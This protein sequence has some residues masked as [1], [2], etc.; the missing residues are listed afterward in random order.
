ME[1]VNTEKDPKKIKKVLKK[2]V[3]PNLNLVFEKYQGLLTQSMKLTD[4]M[5]REKQSQFDSKKFSSMHKRIGY[6]EQRESE[7]L[8]EVN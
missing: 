7:L 4:Q 1:S 8:D 6:F 5:K 2:K 3:M